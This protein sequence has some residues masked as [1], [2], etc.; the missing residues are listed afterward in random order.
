MR[1]GGTAAGGDRRGFP[2]MIQLVSSNRG[3][4]SS[5]FGGFKHHRL[6]HERGVSLGGDV[7]PGEM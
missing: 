2:P 4:Y 6:V 1:P 7:V 3:P 5:L